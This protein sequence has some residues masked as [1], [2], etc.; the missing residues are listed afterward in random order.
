MGSTCCQ[1]ILKILDSATIFIDSLLQCC[2]LF[3]HLN[4]LIND[5]ISVMFKCIHFLLR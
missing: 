4:K 5:V 1:H 3:A 2:F